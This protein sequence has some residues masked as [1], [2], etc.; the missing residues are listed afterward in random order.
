MSIDMMPYIDGAQEFIANGRI[1][2]KGTLTSFASYTPPGITWFFIAGASAFTDA[3]LFQSLGSSILH[4]GTLVGIFL[5]ARLA[6]GL[7]CAYL[8]VALWGLSHIGLKFAE[9]T[10]AR[11][12][13]FFY[14]WIVYLATKWVQEKNAN[15]L[16]AALLTCALGTYYFLEIAPALFILPLIWL[17]FRPPLKARPILVA[18]VLSAVVWYPYLRFQVT[19]DFAD[20]KSQILRESILP[21]NFGDFWCDPSL[22]PQSWRG[23][24]GSNPGQIS[25]AG[26][27][28]NPAQVLRRIVA[29]VKVALHQTLFFNFTN[30]SIIPGAGFIL[31][32]TTLIG[33]LILSAHGSRLA[34]DKI[35]PSLTRGSNLL[36]W[37]GIGIGLCGLLFNEITLPALSS[38]GTFQPSVIASIRRFQ[39]LCLIV[40]ILLI[41]FRE[42][43]ASTLIRLTTTANLDVHGTQHVCATRCITIGMAVPWLLLLM[44]TEESRPARMWWLWSLQIVILASTVTYFSKYLSVSRAS[45][46]AGSLALIFLVIGNDFL[47]SRVAGWIK[48]GWAGKESAELQAVDYISYLAK[49]DATERVAIGY[50]I[51]AKRFKSKFHAVDSRYKVGAD[52]DVFFKSR[53]GLIN[54]NQCPE[55]FSSKDNY[56]IVE[57]Y[58]ESDIAAVKIAS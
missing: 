55:G 24:A 2:E 17:W 53:H 36:K 15:Y 21:V 41:V 13:P 58:R 30:A 46:W 38:D 12:H 9:S 26:S 14:V 47:V 43:L 34:R 33:L 16:A 56:R 42:R 45:I 25:S 23:L 22:V 49:K 6:F 39:I 44:L 27:E 19:R 57:N 51:H 35:V 31:L 54:T 8:S 32:P 1:P 52:F 5:L 18:A 28:V 4:L 20:L 40:A 11:G 37:L 10:W 3:R 50:S 29:R 48:D 7:R